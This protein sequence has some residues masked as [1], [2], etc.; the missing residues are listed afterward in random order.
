MIREQMKKGNAEGAPLTD[1][2]KLVSS[3]GG[4]AISAMTTMPFDR[5]MPVLQ[6]ARSEA[7]GE[8]LFPYMRKRLAQEGMSTLF[9][10]G[11]MRVTHT[12]YHTVFAVFVADK[13]S[14]ILA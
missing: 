5:V 12:T 10:G 14:S 4:G 11:I 13:V 6:A 7:V 3:A 8:G 9:R 1:V 2:Q